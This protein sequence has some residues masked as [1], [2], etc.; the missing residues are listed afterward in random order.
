MFIKKCEETLKIFWNFEI[1]NN[2]FSENDSKCKIHRQR[3]HS[4][5]EI[6]EKKWKMVLTKNTDY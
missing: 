5:N 6:K 4:M 3:R 2:F 1:N